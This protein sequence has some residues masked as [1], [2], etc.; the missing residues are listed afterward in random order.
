MQQKINI[1]YIGTTLLAV[2]LTWLFHEFTHW[3]TSEG[4][5]Y[6]SVLRLN[7]VYSEKGQHPSEL[8][9]V[10]IPLQGHSLHCC[11]PA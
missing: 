4:L 11:K 2:L 10:L 7:A 1:S 5:G 8:H 6:D 9:K 3:C